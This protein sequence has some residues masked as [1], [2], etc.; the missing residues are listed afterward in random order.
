MSEHAKLSQWNTRTI[1]TQ[2][3]SYQFDFCLAKLA[4]SLEPY[5]HDT[6]KL[7]SKFYHALPP[8][9]TELSDVTLKLFSDKL[10]KHPDEVVQITNILLID[11][12]GLLHIK[13]CYPDKPLVILVPETLELCPLTEIQAFILSLAN[14]GIFKDT[15]LMHTWN[16]SI[17]PKKTLYGD[18]TTGIISYTYKEN[19]ITDETKAHTLAKRY[20]L[21]IVHP[22]HIINR[23]DKTMQIN[24]ILINFPQLSIYEDNGILISD[25]I[26]YEYSSNRIQIS[27]E[28]HGKH[29]A[30]VTIQKPAVTEPSF[31]LQGLQFFKNMVGF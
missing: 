27:T 22:I 11:K 26:R 14:I 30:A 29:K 17:A 25:S 8:F 19:F 28:Q 10:I 13:P 7:L 1:S 12:I 18:P 6:I 15:M 4:I 23:T 24:E 9:I 3:K 5:E 21:C 2:K 16:T 31:V 20:P